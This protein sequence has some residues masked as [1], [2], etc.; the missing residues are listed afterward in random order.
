E[1]L[2]VF[3]DGMS[4]LAN[5]D[6][7]DI[8]QTQIVEDIRQK[9]RADWTRRD[10]RDANYSEAWR[11]NVPACLLELL[12]HQNFTDMQYALSPMFRFDVARA[13][14]KGMLKFLATQYRFHYTVQ[15][16]PISHFQAVFS[17]SAEVT[18]RWQPVLDPL[19]PGAVPEKYVIYTRTDAGGF[20]NG[21]LVDTTQFTQ[22]GLKPGVIYSF[23]VSAVNSGGESF[24]SEILSVC[25]Q[26]SSRTPILIINGFDR[27]APPEYI[28][29]PNFKGF[30]NF[31]DPGVADKFTFNLTGTQFDFDPQS[32][33]RTNDAPGHGA[34]SA[35][36]E[37]RLIAGNCF[38]YPF[39]HG[40]AI[41]ACGHSFVSS[42]DEAVWDGQV[43]LKNYRII[44]L[45][46]G[47]EKALVGSRMNQENNPH[48]RINE[49]FRA[50]P[51]KFK[52]NI[53]AFLEAGGKLLLS[54]AYIGSELAGNKDT[55]KNDLKF[56]KEVL[57]IDWQTHHAAVMG[58]VYSV[59]SS[60]IQSSEIF[61]FNKE[62]RPELYAVESPDA[63]DPAKGAKTILR[64]AEN[65]FSAATA[66]LGKDYS[67][68]VL[69]FPFE[70]IVD[71]NW[72]DELMRAVLTSFN[73]R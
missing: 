44:D 50:F 63:I 62:Y 15:P 31:L 61:Q 59:D 34:S 20:D 27:I 2:E 52:A 37:T 35:N 43:D 9:Y 58:K 47:E 72:R 6:L 21:T 5:R 49:N 65:R 23:K 28:D 18:L 13:I 39:I 32:K 10:L 29:E 1:T 71:E 38:D 69:G 26:N 3:P 54:G 30:A 14:Y 16:L 33:F 40:S 17:D 48:L 67:V 11:P 56:A 60:F 57:K 66:Y 4:R 36:Y 45:I 7:G 22:K 53:L 8:L 25:W 24:P 41:R 12:S 19:E 64:Y 42:S 68:I 46:L 70:T 55:T 73:K 51:E